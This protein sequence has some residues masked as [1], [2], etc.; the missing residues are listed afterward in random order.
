MLL[1][2]ATATENRSA[3][4]ILLSATA[5]TAADMARA[6]IAHTPINPGAKAIV[7]TGTN[8]LGDS[9]SADAAASCCPALSLEYCRLGIR[10]KMN[11]VRVLVVTR[12][13]GWLYHQ[14]EHR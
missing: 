7:G 9:V 3:A 11:I 5:G 12:L 8:T 13:A 2:T 4:P 6:G 10:I 1:P 14:R